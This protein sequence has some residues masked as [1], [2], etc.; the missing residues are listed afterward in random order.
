MR[1]RLSAVRSVGPVVVG[2][3]VGAAARWAVLEVLPADQ[4]LAWPLI[5]IN[6]AGCALIGWA[7]VRIE[8]APYLTAIT[9]GFCGAFTSASSF[10]VEVAGRL[11]DGGV[12]AAA[13][14]VGVTVAACG[15]AF[16]AGRRL[17]LLA[18]RRVAW[19]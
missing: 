12:T 13:A 10:A 8:S 17:A 4:P 19:R 16:L 11:D 5:A 3:V 14:H 7:A 1:E 6:V 2:A 9:L 15:I 18:G